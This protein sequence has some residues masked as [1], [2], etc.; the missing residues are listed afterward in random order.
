MQGGPPSVIHDDF[1]SASEERAE[2]SE[3]PRL[4]DVGHEA[5]CAVR[6]HWQ[7][8]CPR[9]AP[10]LSIPPRMTHVYSPDEF[11]EFFKVWTQFASFGSTLLDTVV[12]L[13]PG[14]TMPGGDVS[15]LACISASCSEA[16]PH[17]LA[18]LHGGECRL[19]SLPST[20]TLPHHHFALENDN[21]MIMVTPISVTSATNHAL[22]MGLLQCHAARRCTTLRP[23][24]FLSASRRRYYVRSM[25]LHTRIQKTYQSC[26]VICSR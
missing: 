17:S 2:G 24:T 21:S 12:Y 7:A 20:G 10:V 4:L 15:A 8:V 9:W 11:P 14:D 5:G 23:V 26:V 18:E 19:G 25:G 3:R 22:P 1:R 16:G 13:T 6:Q